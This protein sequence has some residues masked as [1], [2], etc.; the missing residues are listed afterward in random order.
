VYTI[1]ADGIS[2]LID[3]VRVCAALSFA[4]VIIRIIR[5]YF[6]R[7][8]KMNLSNEDEVVVKFVTTFPTF[9]RFWQWIG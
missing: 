8:F 1:Y 4:M 6:H 2:E 7:Y 5:R 9:M 3:F